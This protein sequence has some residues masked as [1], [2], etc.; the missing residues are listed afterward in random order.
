MRKIKHGILYYILLSKRFFKKLSFL[1]LLCAVPVLVF[2]LKDVSGQESGMLHVVLCLEDAEDETARRL[3]DGLMS[4]DSVLHYS[5]VDEKETAKNMVRAGEADAAWIFCSDFQAKIRKLTEREMEGEAPV[6]VI[7]QEDNVALQLARIKMFGALYSD[8]SFSLY[9]NFAYDDLALSG[10]VSEEELRTLYDMTNV[11]GNL[12]HLAYLETDGGTVA[13]KQN[14]MMAPL[15]GMLALLLILCGFEADMFFMQ[16]EEKGVLDG[17]PLRSRKKRV[18]VYQLAAMVPT[19][20]AALAALYLAGDFSNAGEE[21]LFM[22]LYLLDCMV[23]CNGIRRIL[24]SAQWMGTCIPVLMLGMFVLCPVFFNLK[25]F[26]AIQYLLPPF[27]YL[28]AVRTSGWTGGMLCYGIIG[29]AVNF[30]AGKV[31]AR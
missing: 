29:A 11:E 17:T 20:V 28:N 6:L 12:F 23:F 4:E 13:Q 1:M 30:L 19:A 15:R 25:S 18:Y 24:G 21:L 3:A 10:E 26:R 5:L 2:C 9:E 31:K 8:L 27:Y 16:D 14:Y 22:V 7:E